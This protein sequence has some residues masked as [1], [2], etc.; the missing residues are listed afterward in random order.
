MP[1]AWRRRARRRRQEGRAGER[2]RTALRDDL[3]DAVAEHPRE[4]ELA[5][6]LARF[7]DPMRELADADAGQ[8]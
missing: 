4:L 5:P 6:S 8:P 7:L 2:G 3:E 1:A